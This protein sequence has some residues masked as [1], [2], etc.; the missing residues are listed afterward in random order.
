VISWN[1]GPL[2]LSTALPYIAQTKQ[3]ETV[4]FLLQ[5]VFIRKGTTVRFRQEL[6]HMFTGYEY[7]IKMG[8]HVDAGNDKNDRTLTEEYTRSKT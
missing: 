6:R 4:V 3:K 2:H 5:E 8:S 7:F 1:L